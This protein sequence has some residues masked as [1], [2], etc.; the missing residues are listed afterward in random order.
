MDQ[1]KEQLAVVF[2]H[3]F[4]VLCGLV[5]VVS[6]GIWWWSTSQLNAQSKAWM[7]K[8]DSHYSEM[9]AIRQEMD[10]HP[11]AVSH[12]AMD[13]LVDSLK[14]DVAKAWQ[15]KYSQ[16]EDL[17][18]WPSDLGADFVE[19]FAPLKPIE[20]SVDFPTPV[21]Q[22][23][24]GSLRSRYKLYIKNQLP[25]LAEIVRT[26]WNADF[27]KGGGM[28]M[29]SSG[30]AGGGGQAFNPYAGGNFANMMRGGGAAST[31]PT[32]DS[33]I[34]WSAANQQ[35]LIDT[36]FPWRLSEDPPTTL[37]VLYS[38]EDLWVLESVL[39]IIAYVNSEAR[40]RFQAP[41]KEIEWIR[42]GQAAGETAGGIS[43]SSTSGFGGMNQ[44]MMNAIANSMKASL[45]GGSGPAA[46]AAENSPDPANNRYVDT[47]FAPISAKVL[48]GALK[49]STPEN[50]Y[51]T[52][53]KRIPVAMRVKVDQRR[54]PELL[55][56]CANARLMVEVRQVRINV[57]DKSSQGGAG[58]GGFG[59]PPGTP[60]LGIGGAGGSASI[61]ENEGMG[62]GMFG[63]LPA[64]TDAGAEVSAE[65]YGVV[66]FYNPVDIAKLGIE[67]VNKD[68]KVDVDQ[69]EQAQPSG[70]VTA[71][72]AAAAAAAA[73][74]AGTADA[75]A[76]PSASP[77]SASPPSAS[78]PSNGGAAAAPPTEAP[79]A[80]PSNGQATDQATGTTGTATAADNN[81]GTSAT[82]PE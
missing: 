75:P 34:T 79:P 46:K 3:R 62:G 33:L 22:E 57:P 37:E 48:R 59:P 15:Q 30:G 49:T 2:K 9:D 58:G 40:Q 26:K 43:S 47:K 7:A 76:P 68:T 28:G 21:K 53:A 69:G 10:V 71:T 80:A 55:A 14:N 32:D 29:V 12:K 52:V 63:P 17:L 1:L 45:G 25:K 27:E 56:A 39:G 8:L 31:A 64:G 18:V 5:S 74:N 36:L 20:L 54:L 23:V 61:N 35:A 82:A 65:I 81:S 50:A 41:V 70:A 73:A 19:R 60:Q 72:A 66:Y 78:P 67:Q 13:G 38:Q 4:W 51:M 16:Q 24:E 6:L 77:P 44:A 42:I 11:N